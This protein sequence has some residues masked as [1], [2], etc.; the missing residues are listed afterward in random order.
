MFKLSLHIRPRG[1]RRA[2]AL[3]VV[4][5]TSFALLSSTLAPSA[6]AAGSGYN[7]PVKPF[8][9][10]HPVRANFGDPRTTFDGPPTPGALMTSG[11]IFQFHFGID[12]S[13]PDG[14]AVYPVRS[15]VVSLHNPRVVF[16]TSGQSF[17]TQYWHIIPSVKPGQQVTAYR[18]VL[19]RVMK[20][21]EH[22]HFTEVDDGKVVNPLAAGHLEP[23]QDS[24]TP[25]VHSISFRASDTGSEVLPEY[26]HGR[27]VMIARADDM[28]TRTVPGMW[29]NL[30][31]APAL[32]TWRIERATNGKVVVAEHTAFDTRVTIPAQNSFWQYYARGTRQNMSTFA[33]QRAW[34][35]PGVYLYKLSRRP[36]DTKRLPNGIFRLVVT[37][38]DIRG[39]RASSGQIFIVRNTSG[40]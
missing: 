27:V 14:T 21:Y 40:V 18:T 37:A 12:I 24:T 16:V 39:N 28:P 38:T 8:D 4:A 2:I 15:G 30:P 22:V 5:A 36:L 17:V 11:G 34:M 1:I 33:K 25:A 35:E 13:V 3:C 7:W 31:V 9:R 23:Y 29:R 10:P 32:L 6:P 26:L 19:G 20:G